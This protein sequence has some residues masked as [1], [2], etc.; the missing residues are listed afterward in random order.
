MLVET[1]QGQGLGPGPGSGPGALLISRNPLAQ[2]PGA[3][4]QPFPGE[5]HHHQQ[6]QYKQ[7]LEDVLQLV[8]PHATFTTHHSNLLEQKYNAGGNIS[9]G[10]NYSKG[11]QK[12]IKGLGQKGRAK[13]SEAAARNI[14]QGDS[15]R[16]V[17][18]QGGGMRVSHGATSSNAMTTVTSTMINDLQKEF[19]GR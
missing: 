19:F 15:G 1:D 17:G 12:E 5:N 13:M 7:P 4:S 11:Y 2:Y 10:N 18:R 8:Q 3:S 6:Y 9:G 16:D 14:N